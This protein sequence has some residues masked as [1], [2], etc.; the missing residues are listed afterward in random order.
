MEGCPV[1]YFIYRTQDGVRSLATSFETAVLYSFQTTAIPIDVPW[2][3]NPVWPNDYGRDQ[4]I[5]FD[6][7][8][9]A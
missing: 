8:L 6:A 1:D 5:P 3:S 7:N 2:L 4:V 9:Y